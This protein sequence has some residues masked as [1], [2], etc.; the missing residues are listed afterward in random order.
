M[1]ILET[2]AFNDLKPEQQ[3]AM[4]GADMFIDMLNHSTKSELQTVR[5]M[6]RDYVKDPSNNPEERRLYAG[7]I[8]MVST[9][10]SRF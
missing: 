8:S 10:I 3:N 7:I 4:T 5:V 1:S 2:S 9:Q 6:L